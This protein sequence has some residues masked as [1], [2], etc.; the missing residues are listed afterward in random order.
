MRFLCVCC[1]TVAI[2]EIAAKHVRD[3]IG[4]FYF[5][6]WKFQTHSEIYSR[7]IQ[8]GKTATTTKNTY[9]VRIISSSNAHL[10][11][12]LNSCKLNEIFPC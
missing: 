11:N 5:C 1:S 12:V 10:Q 3:F 8:L 9:V 7:M 2:L 6:H 4:V